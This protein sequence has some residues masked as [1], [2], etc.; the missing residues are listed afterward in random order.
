ML[1]HFG[2]HLTNDNNFLFQHNQI[3][4]MFLSDN[5]VCIGSSHM[6]HI[7]RGNFCLKMPSELTEL[8]IN[9]SFQVIFEILLASTV[10]SLIQHV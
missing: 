10:V 6:L 5:I 1:I 9:L 3:L 8:M 2:N 7:Y 4:W